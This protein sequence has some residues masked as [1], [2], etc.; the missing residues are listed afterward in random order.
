[1]LETIDKYLETIYRE[2]YWGYSI[3][4][5]LSASY[6][7]HPN[8]ASYLVNTKTLS[9][10]DMQKILSLLDN[11]ERNNFKKERIEELYINYKSKTGLGTN[12]K[13]NYFKDLEILM[14][15]PG[16]NSEIQ[17]EKVIHDCNCY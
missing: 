15:A 3:A 11:G 16:P 2:N 10:V 8:Y 14:I 4:H 17:K 5:F 9:I 6:A 1:M 7:C 12:F 13:S